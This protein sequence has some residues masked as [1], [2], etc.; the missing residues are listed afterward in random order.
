MYLIKL[1]SAVGPT[2]ATKL[3]ARLNPL[4]TPTK[5]QNYDFLERELEILERIGIGKNNREIALELHLTEST[6]KNHV[7][8]ILSQLGMRDRTQVA[9]WVQQH[10]SLE[11]DE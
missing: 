11:S 1:G 10:L 5:L 7:S 9:L 3:F 4:S 2:I 8:K 6:V